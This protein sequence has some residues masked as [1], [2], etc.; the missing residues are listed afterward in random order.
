MLDA[1]SFRGFYSTPPKM[2]SFYAHE[3]VLWICYNFNPRKKK[4]LNGCQ[5]HGLPFEKW[6]KHYGKLT[7]QWENGSF[8]DVFPIENVEFP[9]AM[10]V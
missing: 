5:L 4:K 8:E 10:L 1:V 9:I 6:L 2:T 3:T 7:W